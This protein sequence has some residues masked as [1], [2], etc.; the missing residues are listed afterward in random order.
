MVN[1]RAVFPGAGMFEATLAAARHLAAPELAPGLALASNTIVSP[2]LLGGTGAPKLQFVGRLSVFTSGTVEL[3]SSSSSLFFS[4]QAVQSSSRRMGLMG[5]E[6]PTRM[7]RLFS[8]V[9]FAAQQWCGRGIGTIAAAKEGKG[10]YWSHPAVVDC[11]THFGALLDIN[12]GHNARVP[13]T[14]GC[15]SASKQSLDQ[16]ALF[17]VANDGVFTAQGNRISTFSATSTNGQHLILT[18]LQSQPIGRKAT[19]NQE[20]ASSALEACSTNCVIYQQQWQS[21]HPALRLAKS[22]SSALALGL[23]LRSQGD[24]TSVSLSEQASQSPHAVFTAALECFYQLSENGASLRAFM[25]ATPA[26]I[27]PGLLSGHPMV[28][29]AMKVAALEHPMLHL[30]RVHHDSRNGYMIDPSAVEAD[31]HGA[32]SSASCISAPRLLISRQQ[33]AFQRRE[34]NIGTGCHIITGG[35]GG[36]GKLAALWLSGTSF[37]NGQCTDMRS[38]IL[39]NRTARLNWSEPALQQSDVCVE[40]LMCNVAFQVD[41]EAAEKTS[42]QVGALVRGI[43]EHESAFS[44]EPNITSLFLPC[45]DHRRFGR[46]CMQ[47]GSCQINRSCGSTQAIPGVCLHPRLLG[48]IILCRA[49]KASQRLPCISLA[50]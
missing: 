44:A 40:M 39:A 33:P 47:L 35:L 22:D 24:E 36:L 17:G 34:S 28:F 14:L 13:I 12:N 46:S 27:L 37:D 15:F 49:C 11:S 41:T 3:G 45:R 42:F 31:V 48:W 6:L 7:L 30:S 38:I 9:S 21:S 16:Q 25:P 26:T 1:G 19:A 5:Q 4:S 20:N 50:A 8:P 23:H 18:E 32:L 43:G 2:I 10:G 29:G